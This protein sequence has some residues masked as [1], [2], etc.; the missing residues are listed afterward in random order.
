MTSISEQ[1][2]RPSASSRA[3][4]VAASAI[5]TPALIAFCYFFVDRPL[6]S[7]VYHNLKPWRRYFDGLTHIIDPFATIGLILLACAAIML[8]CAVSPGATLVKL[9]RIAVA[10]CIA[11]VAKDQLKYAFGRLWPETWIFNNPSWFR[12]GAYG[13]FP[14]H[15]GPGWAAF[16]SGHTTI[17]FALA[18]SLWVAW[19]RGRALYA[20]GAALVVIGLIGANYHWLSDII[21]GA[22]LGT[23]TGLACAHFRPAKEF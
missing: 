13:F 14:F 15:G 18:A 23:A 9:S 10:L 6:A 12:D 20:A 22:A 2:G 17:A 19:P 4:I 11:T 7:L 8:A 3:N 1:A 21:A 16:P 5:A